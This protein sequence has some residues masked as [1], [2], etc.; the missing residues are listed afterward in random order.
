MEDCKSVLPY[1]RLVTKFRELGILDSDLMK[2]L[3]TVQLKEYEP[4]EVIFQK[5]SEVDYF[6]VILHGEV[7]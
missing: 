7:D 3:M 1:F 4:N 6:Y 5:N 2:W